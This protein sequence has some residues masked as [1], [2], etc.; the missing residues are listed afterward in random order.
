MLQGP[1]KVTLVEASQ[2]AVAVVHHVAEPDEET[3]DQMATV[4]MAAAV[5]AEENQAEHTTRR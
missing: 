4:Q 1:R 3:A 5:A 2:P